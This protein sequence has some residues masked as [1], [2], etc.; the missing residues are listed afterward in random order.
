MPNFKSNIG[1][2]GAASAAAYQE[3]PPYLLDVY[4][5]QVTIARRKLESLDR[6]AL[7]ELERPCDNRD[8]N[9]ID[10]NVERAASAKTLKRW[11]RETNGV[12]RELT[13]LL[14]DVRED[15]AILREYVLERSAKSPHESNVWAQSELSGE[16]LS[17]NA[18]S[19]RLY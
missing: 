12:V 10:W 19:E 13:K 7:A 8:P 17:E 5:D 14:N 6:F 2:D 18:A 11:L 9:A 4:R 3:M 15:Q 16:V 1:I